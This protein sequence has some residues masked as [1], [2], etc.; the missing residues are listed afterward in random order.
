MGGLPEG[1]GLCAAVAVSLA[2]TAVLTEPIRRLAL[3]IDFYDRPVGY[4][5]HLQ[6]TPYLGGAA[7]M[8]GFLAG[9]I[10]VGSGAS[11]FV[12]VTACAVGLFV[13]GT[14]DDRVGLGIAPRLGAQIAAGAVLW[15]ADA[16][17][18]I[19]NDL[20][21]LL[22]AVVWVVG[23]TNAFN[24]TDNIDGAAGTLGAVCAAGGGTLAITGGDTVLAA[25]SFALAGACAG[26]LPHNLARPSRI[27]LGDGGSN[28]IGFLLAAIVMMSPHGS[29][30]WIALL[31]SVPMLG[32]PLFDTA[33]VTVSRFRRGVPILRGARDHMTHRLLPVLRSEQ[34]VA[35]VMAIAQGVLCGLTLLLVDLDAATVQ[36]VA[37]AYV[38]LALAVIALVESSSATLSKPLREPALTD[39]D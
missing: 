38:L 9:A 3:Q 21:G 35:A 34:A 16:G 23:V 30:G 13:V 39:R 1:L 17:W 25:F 29:S 10:A 27:F 33:L 22:L 12:A 15:F 19:D 28:A 14:L 24:L 5:K 18:N 37:G 32:L 8:A 20:A 7:V 36:A 26:F 4:K 2:T 6:P 11:Q 31:A